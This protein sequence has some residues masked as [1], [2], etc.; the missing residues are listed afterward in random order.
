MLVLVLLGSTLACGGGTSSSPSS[1]RPIVVA[2]LTQVSAL[3]RAVAGD[4]VAITPLLGPK[5]DPHQYEL[6]PRQTADLGRATVIFESGVGIDRWM[7]R[8]MDAA[9]A[10]GRVTDLSRSVKLRTATGSESTG[11][12]PHWW[13]DTDNARAAAT[14]IA[15]ALTAAD[16]AGRPAYQANADRERARLDAADRSVHAAIDPVPEARRLFVANHDAFGY[17]LARYGVALVGDIVPSTDSIAAVRPADIANLV[18]S[19]KSRHVCAIFTETTINPGLATQIASEASV[20]VFDGK[21]YGDAIGDP[22]KPGGTLE[23]ALTRN[24][25]TMAS[26]FTSC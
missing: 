11:D 14:A 25:R 21:L 26:A 13:Y 22:G 10:S 8:G 17:F 1:S 9:G 20:K 16:P 23:D 15:Q 18:S 3:V 4:R 19:I 6:T 5:D 12:D 2:T 24:G 7:D